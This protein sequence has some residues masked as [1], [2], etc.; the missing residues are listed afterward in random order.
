MDDVH[1]MQLPSTDGD[2]RASDGD[3][4]LLDGVVAGSTTAFGQ[5]YQ[6]HAGLVFSFCGRRSGDWTGAE[7][8]TAVV[9]LEAWRTRERVFLVQ[10]SLRPWLLGI[11]ANVVSTTWRSRR[12]YKA[13]LER[14]AGMRE[15]FDVGQ[16]DVADEAAQ[17]ADN[18]RTAQLVRAALERLPRTQREVVELCLLG[19]LST[20]QAA[21]VLQVPVSTVR[22]RLEDGRSRM[23]RLLRSR[24]IDRTS[25]L[26]GHGQDERPSGAAADTRETRTR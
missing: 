25:W 16:D 24:E 22:S 17:Q 20:T 2:Q 10:G 4:D 3:T 13:A 9:F 5:M 15:A 1:E 26:I 8:L 7:D 18:G 21:E 14:F 11:A 12:R 23:R 19:E 6:R